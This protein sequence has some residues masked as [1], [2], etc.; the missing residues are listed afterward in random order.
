MIQITIRQ[1]RYYVATYEEASFTRAAEREHC[2]QPALSAQI[3]NLEKILEGEAPYD[4]FVRWKP[5]DQQPVGWNPDLN[6]GVRLSIRPFITANVL[7]KNPRIHWNK[8]RGKDVVSAPWYHLF[9]GERI[10]DYHL[11]LGEKR[12]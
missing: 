6:D 9:T 7:R 2:S 8:D 3:A 4:V 11:S 10:N 12:G 1:L 5:L